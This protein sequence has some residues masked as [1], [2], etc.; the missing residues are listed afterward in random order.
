[1]IWPRAAILAELAWSNPAKDWSAFA[2][3]LIDA[4]HRW[5]RMGLGYDAT[6]LNAE[7]RFAGTDNALTATLRQPAAIGTLRYTMTGTPPSPQSPAYT[8][9]LTLAPGT[10]LTV[11]AFLG[12]TALGMPSHWLVAPQLLH[13]RAAADMEL[14]SQSIPIRLEDD[15]AT[16]GVRKVHL[17]DIMHPCWIWRGAPLDGVRRLT[18][19]VGRQPFNFAIGADLA[20]VVFEK[21]AAPAGE[22]K[23][24]RDGCDG[25]VI[26][27]IPLAA[28]TKNA[29]DTTVSGSLPPQSGAHDLCMTF[30]QTGPDPFWVLDRLTLQKGPS[31]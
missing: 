23:V 18:A 26:A 2:P 3:R 5:Q 4:M 15:G 8:Q 21:P 12:E 6:P 28:A 24:R 29:G 14:C 16:D 30:T 1:M 10:P 11:Q 19:T 27:T 31:N 22:L 7:A 25:A 20:K 13:S 17:A 9:P